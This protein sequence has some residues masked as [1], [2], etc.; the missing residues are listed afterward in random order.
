MLFFVLILL[1]HSFT[2]LLLSSILFILTFNFI[3]FKHSSKVERWNGVFRM[4]ISVIILAVTG[5]AFKQIDFFDERIPISGI[6]VGWM[7]GVIL[8]VIIN[9]QYL[10]GESHQEQKWMFV[11]DESSVLGSKFII[12]RFMVIAFLLISVLTFLALSVE[13][14]LGALFCIMLFVVLRSAAISLANR[15]LE[16]DKYSFFRGKRNRRFW[17]GISLSAISLILLFVPRLTFLSVALILF[18]TT[19]V[20]KTISTEESFHEY[21]QSV[22]YPSSL[23]L[24]ILLF[25]PNHLF[26]DINIRLASGS[27]VN[28]A[29]RIILEKGLIKD[30][31]I[32]LY[33]EM[34]KNGALSKFIK[35]D[36]DVRVINSKSIWARPELNLELTYSYELI[37]P[38]YSD[39]VNYY[40]RGSYILSR[41]SVVFAVAKSFETS[42]ESYLDKYFQLDQKVKISIVG[43]ADAYPIRRD[44]PYGREFDY[45]LQET[46]GI[47]CFCN[48]SLYEFDLNVQ[49]FNDN[50]ILAL[51]RALSVR[52]FI[53]KE[54][55]LLH[56]KADV[57]YDYGGFHD[58]VNKGGEY[59]KAEIK[60][61]LYNVKLLNNEE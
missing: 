11:N 23:F 48:N 50:C 43:S 16:A 37:D 55:P 5:L 7:L 46:D 19:L 4:L 29:E 17:I 58:K 9:F 38:I 8:I 28:Q 12:K 30:Q 26:T 31:V 53:N 36:F 21:L 33:E 44:I 42:V 40:Q 41:N 14:P 35:P 39:S 32:K 60:L 27:N 56:E 34:Q 59:R 18:G 20:Q 1:S 22:I 13:I 49:H 3:F 47:K 45:F 15:H 54:I 6:K 2:F 52:D 24:A 10:L 25:L 61:T 57:V 51:L